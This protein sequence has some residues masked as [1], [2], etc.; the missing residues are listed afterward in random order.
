MATELK[1]APDLGRNGLGVP[2]EH[3]VGDT[4][5][6]VAMPLVPSIPKAVLLKGL[7]VHV[8]GAAVELEDQA[9]VGPEE[10]DLVAGHFHTGP[11]KLHTPVPA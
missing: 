8:K 9:L 10:V 2:A 3:P 7:G 6:P 11:W 5:S 4:E 1:H